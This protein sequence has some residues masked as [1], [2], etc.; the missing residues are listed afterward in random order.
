MPA[1]TEIELKEDQGLTFLLRCRQLHFNPFAIANPAVGTR[2]RIR[3]LPFGCQLI[4][5]DSFSFDGIFNFTQL[6]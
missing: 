6:R 4:T 2:I 5:P 3:S 1:D